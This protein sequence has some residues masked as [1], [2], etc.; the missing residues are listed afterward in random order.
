MSGEHA[1]ARRVAVGT[2][3]NALGRTVTLLAAVAATP[4]IVHAVG[5][6]DY[7]TWVLIA[8]IAA[9]GGLFEFGM[10][11]G[12]VKFVAEHTARDEI[13]Q[14][15]R[16][17]ATAAWLYRLI[18]AFFVI[19]GVGL[20]M[21]VPSVLGLEGE[22]ASIAR[23]L[24]TIAALDLGISMLSLASLSVLKGLHRFPVINTIQAVAA[25][26]AVGLTVV[27]VETDAGIVGVSAAWALSTAV[28]TAGFFIAA[29]RLVPEHLSAPVRRDAEAVRRL[30]RH[31]RSIAAV[32]IAVHMQSRL[33]SLV[34][35]A[36]LPVRNVTPYNF[37]QRLADGTVTV[38]DQFGKVLLPLAS[39]ISATRERA[40]TRALFLTST[41]LTIAISLAVGLPIALLGGQ[42]L[43]IWVGD[44]FAGYGGLVAILA[45]AT[46]VDLPSYPAAAVLQSLGR[47]GPIA[48]MATGGA[49]ANIGLSVALVG[50]LG[51]D[52]VALG[53]LIAGGIE[54]IFFVLPYAARVLDISP[55]QFA[56]HILL[57][58]LLPS[59]ALT[60]VVLGGDAILP[61]TS[62]PRL[63]LVVGAAVV[64]FGLAYMALGAEPRERAAYRAAGAAAMRVATPWRSRGS[65]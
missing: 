7:G 54:I 57:P 55:R 65:S 38:T 16:M 41:R 61:V 2:A 51:V 50:P 60:A 1:G 64:V 34:I 42:I 31:S 44:E 8:S 24:G 45:C 35:A 13:D 32:Q 9:I 43:E 58:L 27:A 37:A 17:V 49:V 52:G 62:L 29:R 3:S 19:A 20:A 4:I 46:I 21:W 28:T 10:S 40:A 22:T 18:G 48:W 12:L 47:H 36:A 14:A 56:S 30:V 53:T 59:A 6:T 5:A 11:A 39:E 23:A 25:V 15:A 63:A 33:D 26:L